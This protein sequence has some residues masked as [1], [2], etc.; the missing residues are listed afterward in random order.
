MNPKEKALHKITSVEKGTKKL[1]KFFGGMGK[2]SLTLKYEKE[3]AEKIKSGEY[4]KEKSEREKA[5][6]EHK[7]RVRLYRLNNK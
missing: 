6:K 2:S 4:Q 7:E 3:K 5:Y 1:N